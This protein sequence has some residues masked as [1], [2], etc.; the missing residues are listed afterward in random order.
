MTKM[1]EGHT[2]WEKKNTFFL[3]DF[4]HHT[5]TEIRNAHGFGKN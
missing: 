1:T 5:D 4:F 2:F 3:L